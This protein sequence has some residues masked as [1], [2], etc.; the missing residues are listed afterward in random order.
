MAPKTCDRDPKTVNHFDAYDRR[1]YLR[2][3]LKAN[4]KL[5]SKAFA[6]EYKDRTEVLSKKLH[7]KGALR[8][9]HVFFEY[10][11]DRYVWEEYCKYLP[12][13]IN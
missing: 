11:L 9:G 5:N 4:G 7:S 8:V 6:K 12:L 3:F 2:A 1:D 10:M 13:A